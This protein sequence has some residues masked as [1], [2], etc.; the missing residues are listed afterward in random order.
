[1]GEVFIMR[2]GGEVSSFPQYTYTG[3][4]QY[5]SDGA[6]NW[7]IKFLTSG[8]LTFTKIGNASIVDV[9]MVGGGGSGSGGGGGGSGAGGG[10]GY[11]KTLT[12]MILTENT[13]YSIVVGVGGASVAS[14]TDGKAGGDTSAFSLTAS[15]GK[16]GSYGSGKG[17][18]GG[19]GGQGYGGTYKVA[20]DGADGNAGGYGSGYGQR[21]HV[22]PNSETGTTREF[23]ETNGEL[24]SNGGASGYTGST[25]QTLPRANYGDG[26]HGRASGT[27]S[28]TGADGVVIIRNTR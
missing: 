1:M 4:S 23:G 16:G 18:D 22:G 19:S 6:K 5:L 14:G 12:R 7:R 24:Y 17:G 11:T 9:F 13:P 20:S 2:R 10:G 15:G 28:I 3:A 26:G 21:S 27:T 25:D 8:T